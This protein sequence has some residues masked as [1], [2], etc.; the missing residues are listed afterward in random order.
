MLAE[1]RDT[2]KEEYENEC[3]FHLFRGGLTSLT[4]NKKNMPEGKIF[5]FPA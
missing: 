4:E 1:S 3:F 2:A 5:D